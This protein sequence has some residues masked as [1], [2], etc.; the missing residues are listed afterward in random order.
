M[1]QFD[2]VQR[3]STQLDA[4]RLGFLYEKR[5]GCGSSTQFSTVQTQ[6]DAVRLG[7]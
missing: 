2:A 5:D 3:S 7:S 6:L 4:V 1:W